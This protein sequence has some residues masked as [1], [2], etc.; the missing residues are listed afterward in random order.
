MSKYEIAAEARKRANRLHELLQY[1]KYMKC[2]E[3][4]ASTGRG[5]G[6]FFEIDDKELRNQLISTFN[7]RTTMIRDAVKKSLADQ[8]GHACRDAQEEAKRILGEPWKE[9]KDE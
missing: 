4:K 7:G 6:V 9:V 5:A 8:V 2:R 1:G 3:L